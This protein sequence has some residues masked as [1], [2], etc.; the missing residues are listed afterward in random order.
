MNTRKQHFGFKQ[1]LLVIALLAAFGPVQAGEDEVAN[2]IQPNSTI[3]SVGA[4]G[5]AGARTE[6]AM[7]GQYLGFGENAAGLLLDFELIKRDDDTGTW[8]NAEGRNLGQDNRELSFSRQK[9]GAW[10]YGLDYSQSVRYEPRTVNTGLQGAG[11]SAPTIATLASP[12]SGS[13]LNF[14][15][16]RRSVTL[17]AE[18]WLTSNF[19]LEANFKSE[20]KDGTRM[21]GVG[22][23]CSNAIAGYRCNATMGA[24]LMVPEPISSTANQFEVKGNFAGKGYNVA[25]GYYGSFYQNDSAALQL[26]PI[27]GNLVSLGNLPFSPGSGANT[28]G[29]LLTQPVAMAPDNQAHQLYLSGSFAVTPTTWTTFNFSTTHAAQSDNFAGMGVPAGSGLPANLA[30]EVDSNLYQLGLTARPTTKLSLLA[31]YRLEEIDDKTPHAKYDGTYTNA[32]Y[33]SKKGNVKGE[34]SYRLPE[35]IRATL[36]MDYVW[37]KRNMPAVGS[38]EL[39]FAPGSL[40]SLRESTNELTYRAELRKSMSD[41]VNASLAYMASNRNG[42]H[43]INLGATNP[44]YPSTYMPVLNSY[45][46]SATGIFPTTMM[47]RK[48]DKVRAMVDWMA[49][50]ALSLQLSAESGRDTYSA[51][52][53][54]G[55]NSTGMRS[56]GVDASYSISEIWKLKGYANYGEQSIRLDQVAGYLADIKDTAVS[57]G[58]GV[59]GKVSD[60]FELG[61]D[62]SYLNDVNSYGLRSGNADA[63]GVLPDVTF[64]TTTLKLYGKYALND[65]TDIRVDL[66]HQSM[67]FT[68]WA[69]ANAGIPFA[70]S[71][72]S[73][74]AMQPDQRASYLGVRYVYR[75]K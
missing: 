25:A 21:S 1:N 19:M 47:D 3:V 50:D 46:Y 37:V 36:G 2:L 9:Q 65:Q 61:A 42:S 45:I 29:G 53:E 14:D 11:T 54:A 60:Q 23:Y 51:P 66:I 7:F 63:A 34:L 57:A 49:S 6:R 43:W 5:F 72:N 27:T 28:L 67:N 10:K 35:N 15:I 26:N 59:A 52:T 13:N 8:M 68:E 17:V 71:D 40:T 16:K 31:N 38:T 12:G 20:K 73:T 4:G 39:F 64:R 70:Y 22:A 48:R 56:L 74:V 58:L 33:S 62:L 75:I 24:L 30:G 18:D 55:L 41:S 32:T 44:S 69:W